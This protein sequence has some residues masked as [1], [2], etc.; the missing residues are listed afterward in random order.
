MGSPPGQESLEMSLKGIAVLMPRVRTIRMFGSAALMLAWVACGRL[1]C[2][3]EYDLSSWDIAAGSLL[4]QEAGGIM[5]ALDDDEA[6]HNGEKF[7][8]INR[9]II[10]SD[11][12][13][14]EEVRDALKEA[15]VITKNS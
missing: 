7:N 2:Y 14:H 4:I 6:H 9:K 11:G 5:G 8:I 10:G 13:V 1:G 3:W 12:K 15:G